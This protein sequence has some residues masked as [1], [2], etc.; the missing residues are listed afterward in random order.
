MRAGLVQ[1]RPGL[2]PLC[3]NPVS[4]PRQTDLGVFKSANWA[5]HWTRHPA[6]AASATVCLLSV[7]VS[8]HCRLQVLDLLQNQDRSLNQ[9]LKWGT[10]ITTI[11]NVQGGSSGFLHPLETFHYIPSVFSTTGLHHPGNKGN[12]H[13]WIGLENMLSSRI[14]NPHTSGQTE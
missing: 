2:C 4:G 9:C 7:S 5:S 8:P 1:P 13:F 14:C 6:A 10:I 11:D 3:H 12:Q